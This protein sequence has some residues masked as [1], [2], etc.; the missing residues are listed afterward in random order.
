MKNK[1]FV[2]PCF[3][4]TYGHGKQVFLRIENSNHQGTLWGLNLGYRKQV[5][6]YI[7][8]NTPKVFLHP[9][10]LGMESQLLCI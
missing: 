6:M 1:C 8:K 5:I 10:V 3:F 4:T 9:C 7:E 2:I